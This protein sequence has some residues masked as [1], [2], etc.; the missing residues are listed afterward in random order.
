MGSEAKARPTQTTRSMQERLQLM[1]RCGLLSYAGVVA[2]L[3]DQ[4]RSLTST[5]S[6][7]PSWQPSRA[8]APTCQPS[9]GPA[10]QGE[11]QGPTERVLCNHWHLL[12]LMACSG[13]KCL[14]CGLDC[15]WFVL[16]CAM[17][18]SGNSTRQQGFP[19]ERKLYITGADCGPCQSAA[20]RQA[21]GREA[22]APQLPAVPGRCS[23]PGVPLTTART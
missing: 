6:W 3:C 21:M 17:L 20:G 7:T 23:P 5:P 8:R 19:E 11:S 14:S 13:A 10:C 1:Q 2:V 9:A 16:S 12:Y 22:A 15:V 18:C 4:P